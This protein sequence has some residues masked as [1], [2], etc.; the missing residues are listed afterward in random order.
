MDIIFGLTVPIF[1]V[2]GLVTV[3]RWLANRGHKAG[4][5]PALRQTIAADLRL[6]ASTRDGA[7]KQAWLD[8]AEA[9]V[10][11]PLDMVAGSY[12]PP[13]SVESHHA[14]T[15]APAPASAQDWLSR[16][17][18]ASL[19]TLDNINLLLFLGAFLVVVSAGIFVGYNFSTLSGGFKT[20]FL[21][22]FAG[23]FYGAGLVLFLRAPKLRPA[24]STFA[25][26]G[27]VLLPL[28]GL[29]AYNFTAAHDFGR[30]VWLITSLVTL[31]AYI[32]TLAITR[33][34][35]IAYLMAFTSLSV[36]EAGISL[37]NVPIYWFGWG[38]GL[39]ALLLLTI[40]RWRGLWGD[41]S[42][43]L[44][45]SA[46]IFVPVS[47]FFSMF[48]AGDNGL[49]QF[50]VTIGLA[51]AFYGVMAMRYA[52]ATSGTAYF[53]LA[54]ASLPAALGV[55][56][57][58]QLPSGTVAVV[59]LAV[60]AAYLVLGWT[61][62]AALGRHWLTALG[63]IAG[64]A[65]LVAAVITLDQPRLLLLSLA[66]ASAISALFAVW[67]RS[68]GLALLAILPALAAPYVL[69]RQ[70]VE[71]PLGWGALAAAYLVLAGALVAWREKLRGWP[72]SGDAT[73]IAGYALAL[74]LAVLAAA[75]SGAS[76]LLLTGLAV[77]LSL[78]ALSYRESAASACVYLAAASVA[79]ALL[80]LPELANWPAGSSATILLLAGAAFY[81]LGLVAPD[82]ARAQALRYS[83]VAAP[84][85][86]A[87]F[88]LV[89]A[90]D[91]NAPIAALAVGALLLFAEGRR[92]ARPGV[93]ELAG[94]VML[95]AFN[96]YLGRQNVTQ[97]QFH[98]LPWA[99][100]LAFLAYRRRHLG[101]SVYDLF[102]LAALAVLTF[103]IAGQALADDGQLYG[104]ELIFIA[105]ALVLVGA[106]IKYK[107]LAWW[108]AATLVA[109]VLYQL[110]DFFY[111][112]P[113]YFIS[114]GLGLALL[115]VAIVLLQRRH[116][117]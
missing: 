84:F 59:L 34:T 9:V 33:Q 88:G 62:R 104:L 1:Y 19:H 56:L 48:L 95:V 29:A 23:V 70:V 71:P 90:L 31:A 74:L 8:A 89:T 14:P 51:G 13:A 30:L 100:Y 22:V 52:K 85:A 79:L 113:K 40:D 96:W 66:L 43:S 6:R 7:A 92:A 111:A 36:F 4:S 35:Y 101:R 49:S 28:V 15:P 27:L 75:A 91:S 112:L 73:G 41:S 55:G 42:Q 115:V 110:R 105:I 57:W 68:S 99:A 20:G 67:L 47:L 64:C 12:P 10:A 44:K 94:G 32:A 46:N 106:A 82:H 24:G 107:L 102:T 93:Q 114:A 81:G 80:Q 97:T 11:G 37:I 58:D 109:E 69:V 38:M 39:T 54:L 3:V 72:E 108:G 65:P 116:N 60:A 50:G 5:A 78:Y 45:V 86:G 98:T 25:G 18:S 83:G 53:A 61:A 2:V 87:V 17:I 76:A 103:P 117:N 63:V 16:D 77:G 26:I 21:A